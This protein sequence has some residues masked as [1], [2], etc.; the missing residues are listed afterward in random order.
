MRW[1]FT[2]VCAAVAAA[3]FAP[4]AAPSDLV[5]RNARGVRLQ[6]NDRGQALLTYRVGG[7]LR[8]VLAWGA[9]DAIAPTESR[10]QVRFRLDYSG[11]AVTFKRKV[12]IGFRDR[13]RPYNG[14]SLA[15]LVT[16]C[17]APDGSWWAVQAWQRALP[18][19][20]LTPTRAQ[21][22][23]EF[24][25]SHWR[26]G[27]AEL[28]VN[29]NWAY[30]RYDHLFGRLRYAGQ[31][32][33]G[34]RSTAGGRPLD[35]FGRNI[36]LDTYNSAYGPGWRRENSFLTH[37]GSG[38]FC[39]GLFPNAGRPVGKGERYRATVIGPGVTPDVYWESPAP[40][41]FDRQLDAFANAVIQTLGSQQCKPN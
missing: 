5:D 23:W 2:A 29:T 9:I 3:V 33:H 1:R 32:V 38:A 13:C 22:A 21:A 26:A 16:A 6:V 18:N 40:G 25:L 41:P 4:S 34:F 30:G 20:G 36:Y 37:R 11:G 35:T 27:T 12:W 15:W 17:T 8:R 39:Y 10:R 31:P 24:R 19:H 28:Q 7:T 14:P